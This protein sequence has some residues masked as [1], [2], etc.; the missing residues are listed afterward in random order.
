MSSSKASYINKTR[1]WLYH[2]VL[3]LNLCPFAKLPFQQSRIQYEVVLSEDSGQLLKTLAASL[4]F[5]KEH[6][7]IE[8]TLIIHPNALLDFYAYLDFLE[9]AEAL[10]I[11]LG[12]EGIFQVASF[13][14]NYQFSGT[15]I[16]DVENYTNRS[17]YPMLHLLREDSVTKAAEFYPNVEGIPNR[18]IA[19]LKA[20]GISEVKQM[21]QNL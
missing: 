20:L 12:Y 9:V 6:S 13:H 4:A 1:A 7:K 3:G 15:N 8:T 21:Y 17:P 18:N 10:L 2:F 11:D 16:E 14:P 19:T 5:L